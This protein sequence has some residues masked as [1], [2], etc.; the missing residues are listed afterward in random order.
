MSL[1]FFQTYSTRGLTWN[2]TQHL[3]K[4]QQLFV[5]LSPSHHLIDERYSS[6]SPFSE[7]CHLT[8]TTASSTRRVNKETSESI[9]L[10]DTITNH[11]L[12]YSNCYMSLSS[13][14]N[15]STK[16]TQLATPPKPSWLSSPLV[17]SSVGLTCP[18]PYATHCSVQ[19]QMTLQGP[20]IVCL[21]PPSPLG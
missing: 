16:G 19:M 17:H 9:S 1:T 7:C 8:C 2:V 6:L 20:L 12:S 15:D 4:F 18:S 10:L 5:G 3:P 11:T 21:L 13:D 14:A